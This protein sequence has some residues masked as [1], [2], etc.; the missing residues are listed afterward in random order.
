[1]AKAPNRRIEY[2]KI[3][4]NVFLEAYKIHNTV[5]GAARVANVSDSI[6]YRWKQKDKEFKKRFD[7]IEKRKLHTRREWLYERLDH[8]I[9][10]GKERSLLFAIDK[11]EE[12]LGEHSSR[13]VKIVFNGATVVTTDDNR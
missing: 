12:S 10:S 1:M 7:A 4:Q 9:E 3:R 13:P 8:L 6:F 5:L 2:T 11:V